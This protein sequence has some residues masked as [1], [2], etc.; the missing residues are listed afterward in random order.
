MR[1]AIAVCFELMKAWEL[2]DREQS[3]KLSKD[4]ERCVN[5]VP[6][7]KEEKERKSSRKVG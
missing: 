6:F 4:L 2:G 5:F 3:Q 1:N 7:K